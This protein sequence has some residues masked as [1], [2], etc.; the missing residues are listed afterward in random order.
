VLASVY[1]GL[2]SWANQVLAQ[3]DGRIVAVGLSST[4]GGP[5]NDFAVMRFMPDGTLDSSFSGDRKQVTDISPF[6]DDGAT[7]AV[8]QSDGKIV[9][10]G[11][12]YVGGA[13]FPAV[14]RYNPD[15]SL[16][17]ASALT[18]NKC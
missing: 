7:T 1:P 5:L 17:Q 11:Y 14:V 12:A 16:T 6:S 2:Y 18:A 13:Y 8:L 3:P 10:A 4:A 9:A 15:G